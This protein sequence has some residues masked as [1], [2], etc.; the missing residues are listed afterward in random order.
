MDPWSLLS[1]ASLMRRTYQIDNV[2]WSMRWEIIFSLLAPIFVWVAIRASKSAFLGVTLCLIASELGRVFDIKA[3]VYLPVFLA[4]ALIATRLADLQ[5]RANSDRWR[6]PLLGLAAAVLL[7]A[8]WLSRPL[9]LPALPQNVLWGLAAAG[10]VL[11]VVLAVRWQL[12]RQ[13]LETRPAQWLGKISFSLF[14]IHVPIIATATYFFGS[15]RWWLAGIVA[16]PA[17]VGAAL[18]FQRWIETPT[19]KLARALGARIPVATKS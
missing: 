7:I 6:M 18:L 5:Q 11:T 16:M 1:E 9:H 8:S 19:H 13:L 15:S 4:G 12:M 2:L 3:L 17:S 10:A 14:L